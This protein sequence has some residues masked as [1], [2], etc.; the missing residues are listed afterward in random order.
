[1]C[2]IECQIIAYFRGLKIGCLLEGWALIRDRRL[3]K[4]GAYLIILYLGVRLIE[5]SA[6]SRGRLMEALGYNLIIV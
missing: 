1:M 4:V 5:G 2:V 6:Y 3:F